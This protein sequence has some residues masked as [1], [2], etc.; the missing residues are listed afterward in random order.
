MATHPGFFLKYGHTPWLPVDLMFKGV[1]LGG[2]TVDMATY[3]ESL[4]KDLREA[5]ALAQSNAEE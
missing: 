5:V 4:G 1:L 3:V 2:D